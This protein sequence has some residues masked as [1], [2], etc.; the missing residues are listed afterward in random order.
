[1]CRSVDHYQ[2]VEGVCRLGDLHSGSIGD[3][4]PDCMVAH[5]DS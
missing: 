5:T 3:D 4:R 2:H 1:V